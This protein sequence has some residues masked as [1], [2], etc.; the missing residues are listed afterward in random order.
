MATL[1]YDYSFTPNTA[2]KA[3][4]VNSNF[5]AVK[6]FAEGISTGANIDASAITTTKINDNA[7]NAAKL[8]NDAVTTSKILNA[9]VTTDKLAS[10]AVTFDKLVASAPRGVI[11][12]ETRVTD[13]SSGTNVNCFTGITFTPVVGRLYRISFGG[14]L[15]VGTTDF[16]TYIE[17]VFVNSSNTTLQYISQGGLINSGA[18]YVTSLSDSY[19]IAPSTTTPITLNVRANR[20]NGT[21]TLYFNGSATKQ[22]YLLV[23]DIGA[24]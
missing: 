23:E 14:F 12:R 13:T 19:L 4:E 10:N 7:V 11:A 8:A 6:A 16:S 18:Q 1:N 20:T 22:N 24:A 9:N 5:S 3:T 2:A 15:A 21:D 17:V